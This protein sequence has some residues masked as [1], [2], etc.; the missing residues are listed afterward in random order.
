MSRIRNSTSPLSAEQHPHT[1][2]GVRRFCRQEFGIPKYG[3]KTSVGGLRA[4][5]PRTFLPYQ[6]DGQVSKRSHIQELYAR[7]G[8]Q[9]AP[10]LLPVISGQSPITDKIILKSA[11]VPS[12]WLSSPPA[13]K[14]LTSLFSSTSSPVYASSHN[15]SLTLSNQTRTAARSTKS[16]TAAKAATRWRQNQT[17]NTDADLYAS[18]IDIKCLQLRTGGLGVS[19]T[20]EALLA[21]M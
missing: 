14:K 18:D 6:K 3:P 5:K 16:K 17:Q 10:S 13:Q 1:F 12:R 7:N 9:T 11:G 21:R 4:P 8:L 15:Q 19:S 2:T 20:M